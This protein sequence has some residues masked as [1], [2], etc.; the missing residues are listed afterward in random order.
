MT[1]SS[2]DRIAQYVGSGTST[3]SFQ[4]KVFQASDLLVV[5]QNTSTGVET[6]LTLTTDYTVTL[7]ADQNYNPGGNVITTSAVAVGYNL[8]I[9]SDIENLQPTD[10]SNQGGFYPDVINESLDRATIQ[11][12]QLADITAR[13]MVAP[14]SDGVSN[15]LELPSA[16]ERASKYLAFD[17]NGVPVASSGNNFA[18]ITSA[19]NITVT[20]NNGGD[21]TARDVIFY[22]NATETMRILGSGATSK[23]GIGTASPGYKLSLSSTAGMQGWATDGTVQQAFAYPASTLAYAGTVSNHPYALIANNVERMRIDTSGNVGIGTG[24]PSQ[25]LHVNGIVA[26]NRTTA[27]TYATIGD[28]AYVFGADIKQYVY[29]IPGNGGN[30]AIFTSDGSGFSEPRLNVNQ[31]GAQVTGALTTSTTATIGTGLGVTTGGL[32]VG[33]GQ[34]LT[35]PGSAAAPSFSITGDLTTGIYQSAAQEIGISTNG[36]NRLKIGNTALTSTTPITG[37][38]I[39][40]GASG[41]TST[42]GLTVTNGNTTLAGTLGVA[43]TS[44]AGTVG[45]VGDVIIGNQASTGTTGTMRLV[46]SA[47]VNYIQ[48][49]QAATASSAATLVVCSYGGGSEFMRAQSAGVGIGN[50]NSTPSARLHV[51]EATAST[52]TQILLTSAVTGFTSSDGVALRLD[53]S[54]GSSLWNYENTGMLF[55]TNNT[56]KMRIEAGGNVGIG[57]TSPQANARLD[58]SGG[59]IR[60]RSG[61]YTPGTDTA[62]I[63][64]STT[65]GVTTISSRHSTSSE[66]QCRVTDS[67][68]T[69]TLK[70]RLTADG[71][72]VNTSPPTCQFEVT[73]TIAGITGRF[74]N[75]NASPFGIAVIYTNTPNGTANNFL[76]CADTANATLRAEI[77]S[78]GG[79]SNFTANN[80]A[81]SDER[82]KTDIAPLES[83]WDTIKQIEIVE[84]KYRDQTHTDRN[85][86]VIAQQVETVNPVWV[87]TEG[88]EST[89]DGEPTALKAV[90][91]EDVKYAAI[92]ALQEAMLR[93]EQ[94]EARIAALE[95]TP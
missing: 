35:P 67:G 7:N 27:G 71:L 78:N 89:I 15:N 60:F 82:V 56:E 79:I 80:V 91:D 12:Q 88:W 64:N 13:S 2:N 81:L 95:A 8:T 14:I 75:T 54:G 47:G 66:I 6:T 40:A 52:A 41:L 50:I 32:T 24:S 55:A 68:G 5:K 63:L 51:H 36:V 1:I 93:I 65:G 94:L 26:S 28:G 73:E 61:T 90:Y 20:A 42:G 11:I 44:P 25:K 23:V 46:S 84:F 59:G 33:A 17:A 9:T 85:I 72:G 49:A 18:D 10:L 19:G 62:G 53:A 31:N 57:T 3:F 38:G 76:R 21:N 87:E 45:V 4:F 70:L 74:N 22:D 83:Q 43:T 48:S 37:P 92:K 16:T 86:G 29:G 39:N 69:D 77:R 34:V 58:V 30:V